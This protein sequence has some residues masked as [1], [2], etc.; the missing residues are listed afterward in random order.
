VALATDFN[1]GSSHINNISFIWTLAAFQMGM[2]IEE[3]LSAYTINAAKAL[4][5]SNSIGS[6]EVGKKADFSVFNVT[7]YSELLYHM[8]NN[9]NSMTI[10]NGKVI[11]A[12]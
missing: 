3:I 2:T 5:L 12:N 6:I 7:D 10:K 9:L 8:T 1:P 11:Y 4:G